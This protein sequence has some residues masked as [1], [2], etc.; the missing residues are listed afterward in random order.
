MT[1]ITEVPLSELLDELETNVRG[2]TLG[3]HPNDV[4]RVGNFVDQIRAE[5]TRRFA[6]LTAD[7]DSERRWADEYREELNAIESAIDNNLRP[8]LTETSMEYFND[9]TTPELIALAAEILKQLYREGWDSDSILIDIHE[10][11]G[12]DDIDWEELPGLVRGLAVRG[13]TYRRRAL[14]LLHKVEGNR[15][16][17]QMVIE[18]VG[19]NCDLIL[20][21]ME[22][23]TAD[24]TE[25][26]KQL[27]TAERERD[28]LRAALNLARGEQSLAIKA[29]DA[30]KSRTAQAAAERDELRAACQHL[31][32]YKRRAPFAFEIG[33]VPARMQEVEKAMKGGDA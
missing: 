19:I 14:A 7:R 6:D 29:Y 15:F 28:E 16:Q 9:K 1:D 18:S 27:A 10:I 17:T 12:S 20:G 33:A 32:N 11:F 8:A 22:A 4:E 26:R 24:N 25:L 5:I 2:L 30:E 3:V 23:L 31:I 13:D 21:K